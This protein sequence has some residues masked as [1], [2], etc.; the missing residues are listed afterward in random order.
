M[1]DPTQQLHDWE[2]GIRDNG[3]FWTIP[4]GAGTVDA[5]VRRGTA[6][7]R[8]QSVRVTDYHDFFNAVLGGGPAPLP[9]RVDFEVRWHGGGDSVTLDDHDFGFGGRYVTGPATVSFRAKNDHG[10]V[11]YESD[12]DGQYNPG[13]DV[14][15]AGP[16]AVGTERNGQFFS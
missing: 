2:P 15:G 14:F 4:I 9:A 10:D 11:L 16:P 8:G 5:N 3:L 12:P 13:T 7:F 6:T 1:G